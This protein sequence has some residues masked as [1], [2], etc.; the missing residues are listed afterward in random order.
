[1]GGTLSGGFE[2]FL[3]GSGGR[4]FRARCRGRVLFCVPAVLRVCFAWPGAGG[5]C[6]ASGIGAWT[7][8]AG[9]VGTFASWSKRVLITF[10][11][12]FAVKKLAISGWGSGRLLFLTA[13]CCVGYLWV[14]VGVRGGG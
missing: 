9:A 10:A 7:R 11:A 12:L 4:G 1:M 13:F 5:S 14:G 8:G 6:D 3:F 2:R